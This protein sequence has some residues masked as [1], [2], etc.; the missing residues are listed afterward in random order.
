MFTSTRLLGRI[1][2]DRGTT[3]SGEGL[4]RDEGLVG[5]QEKRIYQVSRERIRTDELEKLSLLYL[6]D[7]RVFVRIR[8]EEETPVLD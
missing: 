3:S 2:A 6:T 7:G 5:V 1:T 4:G 8:F